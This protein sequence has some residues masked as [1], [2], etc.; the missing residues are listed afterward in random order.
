[1]R[2]E[3]LKKAVLYGVCVA[4]CAAGIWLAVKY[5][6]PLLL[7]FAAAYL[8]SC[9][10]RP[11][12]AWLSKKTKIP[13]GVWA[14]AIVVIFAAGITYFT[15]YSVTLLC[16]EATDAVSRL[17]K[18]L[19]TEGNP[20]SCL[21]EKLTDKVRGFNIGGS[22]DLGGTVTDMLSG[23]A[24]ALSS[25]AAQLAGDIIS[26]APS[27]LF[28][29]FVGLISL[30]YFSM[31]IDGIVRDARRFLPSAAINAVS[32]VLSVVKRA[33]VRFAKAYLVLMVITFSE[34]LIGFTIIGV[35][36]AFLMALLTA[37]IDILPVLGVGTVLVPWSAALFFSGDTPSALSMLALLCAMY[38]VRQIIEPKVMG[39]SAGVHPV[40][41]LVSVYAGYKVAGLAG[42][43][44]APVI[45]NAIGVLWEEKSPERGEKSKSKS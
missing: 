21:V 12:A 22:A 33:L 24:T 38:V 7:P 34:L 18:L 36:F 39:S 14:A 13:K 19:E 32:G 42:M 20:V 2:E 3:T 5:A 8:L 44:A 29:L 27:V 15:Y 6:L 40:I 9:L 41:A 25:Y 1:M 30:F 10:V 31:D 11:A 28:S 45:L 37:V 35:D 16:R 23:A 26:R 4:L 43:I 17:M